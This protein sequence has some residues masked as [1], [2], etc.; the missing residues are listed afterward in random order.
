LL[1]LVARFVTLRYR[2]SLDPTARVEAAWD[3]AVAE[4]NKQAGS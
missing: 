2:L 4:H 3:V 1:I